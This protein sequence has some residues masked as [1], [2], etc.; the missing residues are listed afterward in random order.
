LKLSRHIEN[1][2]DV[3]Y[4]GFDTVIH[5]SAG[6]KPPGGYGVY[7]HSVK[8]MPLDEL[9]VITVKSFDASVNSVNLFF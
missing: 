8:V 4:D 9:L 6:Y 5:G 1:I 7:G 2:L 3:L